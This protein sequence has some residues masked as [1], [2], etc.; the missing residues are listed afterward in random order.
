M[1][2]AFAQNGHE[3][4]LI[5]PVPAGDTEPGVEHVFDFYGVGACFELVRV[6][7]PVRGV[8]RSL[9]YAWRCGREASRRRPDIV[10]GRDVCGCAFGARFGHATVFE[11][12]APIWEQDLTQRMGFVLLR[13]ATAFRR[14]VVISGALGQ[15]YRDR[16]IA[17][18]TPITVAHDGAFEPAAHVEAI[19]WPARPAS[20]QVG[21]AGSLYPGKGAELV[22]SLARR[23]P[24][25][26]FHV[27]GGGEQDLARWYGTAVPLNVTVHGFVQPGR[28]SAY[29]ARMDV[30]LLPNQREVR[31]HGAA[32]GRGRGNIA[33]FTSPLK[34]FEYMAHGKAIVA[35]DLPVLREVLN[36]H[37][38][39]LVAPDDIDAWVAAAQRLHD[40]RLRRQLGEQAHRDFEAQ[41]KWT[42]RAERVIAGLQEESL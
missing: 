41:Y 6:P 24:A 9:V 5:A 13:R 16:G 8:K 28:L 34:L 17:D 18:S 35:S 20:L 7:Y 42:L 11:S 40:S 38:A 36:E 23:M 3:T 14:L 19:P 33:S 39:I 32:E 1:C 2:A 27:I 12:H 22:L 21:Y 30:C 15:A 31:T 4:A 25:C 37:N 10:Y 29:L 26:D